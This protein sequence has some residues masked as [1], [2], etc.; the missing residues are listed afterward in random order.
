MKIVNDESLSIFVS[1]MTSTKTHSSL[2]K[3]FWD[4]EF[5]KWTGTNQIAF[6]GHLKLITKFLLKLLKTLGKQRLLAVTFLLFSSEQRSVSSTRGF[7]PQLLLL[8]GA[9]EK[10]ETTRIIES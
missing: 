2:R 6:K 1:F 9:S 7:M 8:L 3:F 10:K 5:Q 4:L